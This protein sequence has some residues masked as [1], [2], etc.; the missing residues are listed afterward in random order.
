MPSRVYMENK[1]AKEA[2]AND[3]TVF[4]NLRPFNVVYQVFVSQLAVLPYFAVSVTHSA[5][6]LH[7][8]T[9]LRPTSHHWS[10]QLLSCT[11]MAFTQHSSTS[12]SNG[13][14]MVPFGRF[15]IIQSHRLAPTSP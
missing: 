11:S 14:P 13:L 15:V 8:L 2:A 4:V 10:L 3:V 9:R 5:V 7:L 1:R 6:Y 12:C